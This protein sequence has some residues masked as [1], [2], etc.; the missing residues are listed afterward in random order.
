M[1]SYL[2]TLNCP[3]TNN[4]KYVGISI[5]PKKRFNDHLSKARQNTLTRKNAWIKGL[6]NQEKKPILNIVSE[7]NIE[8]IE[9]IEKDTIFK[10]KKEGLDLYNLTSGG[11]VKKEVSFSTKQKLRDINLGKKQSIETINKRVSLLKG[12]KRNENTKRKMSENQRGNNNSM[13]KSGIGFDK[14][15]QAMKAVNTGKKRDKS[16]GEKI[17]KKLSISIVQLDIQNNFIKEWDSMMEVERQLGF[18]NGDI[19]AVCKGA[20]RKGYV[21]KTA[22]GFKWKYKKDYEQIN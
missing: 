20:I 10:Y 22:Y 2:Y 15:I 4:I 18:K 16:V 3:F 7:H 8:D 12:Q 17:S 5:N 11:E 1:K 13:I 21:R 9:Q 19:S 14:Q 6:L